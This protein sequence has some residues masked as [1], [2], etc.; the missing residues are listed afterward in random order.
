MVDSR[1]TWGDVLGDVSIPVSCSLVQ[2]DRWCME[3]KV[4]LHFVDRSH[5]ILGIFDGQSGQD[6]A[7]YAKNH[8]SRN[9]RSRNNIY[10]KHNFPY[11]GEV[12]LW[13]INGAF[14]YH[15]YYFCYKQICEIVSIFSYS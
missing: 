15:C 12:I 3:D 4:A 13:A 8:M 10:T 7:V 11:T 9:H 2:G 5:V 14:S 6:A 1:A